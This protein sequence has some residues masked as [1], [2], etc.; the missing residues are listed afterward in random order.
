MSQA[1][2]SSIQIS[3]RDANKKIKFIVGGVLIILAIAYLMYAGIQSNATY[4]MTVDELYAK[5]TAVENK[6]VRVSGMVDEESI[7]F[8]NRDL[9][10]KF[11]VLGENGKALPV[12]FN[13]PKPD[14]MRA[15]TEAIIEGTYNGHSFK[16]HNLLLKCPSKY[17]GEPEEIELQAIDNSS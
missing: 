10:L 7:E 11:N 4:F 13:G 8:N 6:I 1:G 16:A 3:E 9:I 14:Q 15:D 2:M 5:G 12:V 17:E